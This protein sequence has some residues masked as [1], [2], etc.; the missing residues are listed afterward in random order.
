MRPAQFEESTLWKPL[1]EINAAC[2]YAAWG[3]DYRPEKPTGGG[4]GLSSLRCLCRCQALAEDWDKRCL[5]VQQPLTKIP[6][7]WA[8]WLHV[9][10]L[11]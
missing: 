1:L 7:V 2:V 9:E 6:R 8:G 11:D 4:E 5:M 3:K 10:G